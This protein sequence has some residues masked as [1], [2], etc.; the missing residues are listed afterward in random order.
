MR[1]NFLFGFLMFST[2][3]ISQVFVTATTS[4]NP[5][6]PD[7]LAD[8]SIVNIGGM[9][10]CYVTTDGYGA[11]L[12]RS[13]PPV[14]WKSADFVN[15][16]FDGFLQPSAVGQK[17]WAPSKPVAVNG[18]YYFY[19]T[20]NE[21]IYAAVADAPTGPF[22]LVNGSD[23]FLGTT[24]AKPILT[25]NGPRGTKG[26]DAEVFIDDNG[27]AYLYW[28]QRGAAKLKPDMYTIDTAITVIETK[29]SGYSEGPIMFK[30]KGIYYYCYTLDGHEQYKYA[31]GFSKVSPLGPFT[32]PE[33][34][35]ITQTDKR[36]KIYGP[37]H[38]SV[39]SDPLT[40]N[41]YFAYLEFGNGGTNRQVWVDKLEFND[42]GTIKP[43]A[44][45]HRGVGR[46]A[47]T[48]AELSLVDSATITASSVRQDLIVKPVKDPELNRSENY[49]PVNAIDASNRTRWLADTSDRNPWVIVDLGSIKE[50]TRVEAYF[51]KPTAGHAY[52]LA[53]S[54]DG[55]LWTACGGHADTRVQSPHVDSVALKARYLKLSILQGEAGLWE[56]NIFG[57]RPA[58]QVR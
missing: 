10:Y 2:T 46:L 17:Y 29:R 34:D 1:L 38:G 47:Q 57:V 3:A 58:L 55:S 54:T 30:R 7:L 44:L 50:V 18:K 41:Y 42:D 37:G 6:I 48:R 43:L 36:R 33:N 11:G 27:D 15:W 39:F 12:A 32:Y 31:Y 40:D 45:T 13:G 22:K 26:I 16:S 25:I 51:S 14:V 24:A 5:V 49:Q 52:Q 35:I 21:S 19:P 8:P 28:A 9:Y 23:T 20:I 53:S 4:K 56:F